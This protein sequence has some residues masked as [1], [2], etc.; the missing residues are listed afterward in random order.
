VRWTLLPIS[1]AAACSSS[2]PAEVRAGCN[3]LVGDN[4]LTPFPSSF[5]EVASSATATGFQLSIPMTAVPSMRDGTALTALA[6]RDNRHD[7]ISP[8]TPFVVYFKNGVDATQLPTVDA[9]DQSVTA[10]ST[11][12]VLDYATGTRVP[13]FA[14][15]DANAMSGGRQA[16]IIH[17]MVRLAPAT[18]YIV[19]LVG[20]KAANGGAL[21]APGFTALRDKTAL[22]DQLEPLKDSYEQIFTALGTAGVTRSTV[23]LAWDLTTASDADVTGHLVAMRD[24]ALTMTTGLTWTIASTTDTP[25]DPNRLRE[26]VGTF[27]VP[28]FLTDSS[29]TA[30]LNV[31][32]NGNPMLNGMGSANF[33]VDIPQCAANASAPLPVMV[34]GHGLF[35]TAVSEL[36]DPYQKQVGNYLCMVQIGTDWLGLAKY[37][38]PTIA[39]NVI[40]DFNNFNM[41]TDRLQ[42]AHVNAQV[43][44]RLFITA[45]KNDPALQINSVPVT[46]ASQIYYYGISNGGIQ[47]G[48]Y[49]GLAE[50][51]T[52]GVLNVPGGDWT[53]LMQRSTDFSTL[54]Q[55]LDAEIPDY[56]DQQHL[57]AL[58]QPEWDYTDPAGFAP[59][60]LASPLPSAPAKQ[61]LVQEAI[62]DAQVTNLATRVIVRTVGLPGI[63]LEQ[64]VYGVTEASAPL[65]SAYTQWDI[66]PNP[67]PPSVN[68]PAPSDNGAHTEIRKLVDLEAQIRAFLT[69]TGMVT[70]TCTGPCVCNFNAGTQPGT[71]NNASD[72]D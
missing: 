68:Q 20:L 25:S 43:L 59:H 64:P 39:T 72:T 50:D 71:C 9:L 49:M 21:D 22:N 62:N 51:V 65:P 30:T 47:G 57:L 7:G 37:D 6:M 17:P 2:K 5:I 28:L 13:V 61:I 33:V 67:V 48:T 10:T 32:G 53:L 1:L 52:R 45:M 58:L 46:D 54:Q 69:P 15:L 29:L 55:L 12:Q 23:T 63:D 16:L 38:Y 26:V 11:V 27:Q 18:R 44:T 66:M 3:P 8:S 40:P 35:G 42:Q 70:Q 31:D 19:A 56:L 60:L 41:V 24:Q 4:C 36:E 14:E 34:F